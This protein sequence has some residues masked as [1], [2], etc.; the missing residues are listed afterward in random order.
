VKW[1]GGAL[2]FW[3]CLIAAEES[4]GL[5]FPDSQEVALGSAG[6]FRGTRLGQI[7]DEDHFIL[8]F[9]VNQFI[10][11]GLTQSYALTAGTQTELGAH[12]GDFRHFFWRGVA[13][14]SVIQIL[15]TEAGAGIGD[16]MGQQPRETQMRGGNFAVGIEFSAPLDGILQKFAQRDTERLA[17]CVGEIG[18]EMRE[19]GL[20]ALV[21]VARAGDQQF[22]PVRLGGDY[23]DLQWF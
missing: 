18:V 3:G 5:D 10:G 2:V 22:D 1:T 20:N 11:D 14:H 13:D 6:G 17:Q 23:F 15:E 4:P 21:G 8:S 12:N 9:V 7:F 16:A 19:E